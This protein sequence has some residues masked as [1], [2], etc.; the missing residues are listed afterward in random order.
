[1]LVVL[2]AG[3]VVLAWAGPQ[4][5]PMLQGGAAHQ[6]DASGAVPPPLKRLWRAVPDGA[7]FLAAVVVVPG[8]AVGVART[9]V[10]G[11]D[12]S[13]G[14]VIWTVDRARGPLTQPGRLPY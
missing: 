14:D 5:W 1:M 3:S 10:V 12:P 9:H 7:A 6:G 13:T 4:S 11:L 8:L 2:S